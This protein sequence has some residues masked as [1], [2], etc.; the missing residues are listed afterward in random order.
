MTLDDMLSR[1]ALKMRI[2][3]IRSKRYVGMQQAKQ[4]IDAKD[5]MADNVQD[6]VMLL[7]K[8]QNILFSQEELLNF[9]D[10]I[11]HGGIALNHLLEDYELQRPLNAFPHELSIAKAHANSAMHAL[12]V[13]YGTHGVKSTLITDASLQRM[14]ELAK[15][16][17]DD[18]PLTSTRRSNGALAPY[19]VLQTALKAVKSDAGFEDEFFEDLPNRLSS[20]LSMYRLPDL[21]KRAIDAQYI[22]RL[23]AM[24]M[25]PV[26]MAQRLFR[27][28]VVH[29]SNLRR[30]YV[31]SFID[32]FDVRS[33]DGLHA[34]KEA[35]K[36]EI[37]ECP[38]SFSSSDP[39]HPL[40]KKVEGYKAALHVLGA[41]DKFAQRYIARRA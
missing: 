23:R 27:D 33:P 11:E 19:V 3:D 8:Q 4:F 25:N 26:Q 16:G 15:F 1:L 40:H 6:A 13:V 41:E 28:R 14:L 9:A 38:M 24:F 17:Y 32:D 20:S 5:A 35:M 39:K 34:F 21:S 2:Q 29:H 12:K 37:R 7:K 31:Q 36:R 30:Q 18:A 22:A 10:G